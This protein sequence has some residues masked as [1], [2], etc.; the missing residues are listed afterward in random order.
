MAKTTSHPLCC[1]PSFS[2]WP[3]SVGGVSLIEKIKKLPMNCWFSCHVSSC[4]CFELFFFV[5]ATPKCTVFHEKAEG[6]FHPQICFPERKMT[7]NDLF[8]VIFGM[9][10]NRMDFPSIAVDKH[11]QQHSLLKGTVHL[12]DI[13]FFNFSL[14]LHSTEEIVHSVDSM[15]FVEKDV[16]SFLKAVCTTNKLQFIS[17]VFISK[18][19]IFHNLWIDPL[20]YIFTPLLKK[21]TESTWN[22]KKEGWCAI[23]VMC[24]AQLHDITSSMAHILIF[25]ATQCGPVWSRLSYPETSVTAAYRRFNPLPV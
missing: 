5:K 15:L 12:N 17:T 4:F 11:F 2:W 16:V 19:D 14:E 18:T 7:Q 21:T 10:I 25:W 3:E 22:T 23:W 1:D 9:C 24:R 8:Q 13:F 6:H 20:T